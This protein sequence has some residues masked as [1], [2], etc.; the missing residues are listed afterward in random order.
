MYI[1][2]IIF[3]AIKMESVKEVS[4]EFDI[5]KVLFI[6]E[7]N[8][9]LTKSFNK[10]FDITTT[11]SMVSSNALPENVMEALKSI[12]QLIIL[13]D[14]HLSVKYSNLS[15]DNLEVKK[16]TDTVATKT[17]KY[18]KWLGK[19]AVE[20][21]IIEN[22]G[23]KTELHSALLAMND[24]KNAWSRANRFLIK[25]QV[26]GSEIDKLSLR[27]II[28]LG[29]TFNKHMDSAITSKDN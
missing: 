7:T 24:I 10:S 25:A 3:K 15:S 11:K 13:N 22:G 23:V 27:E 8:D 29:K 4:V 2:T 26:D 18:P 12:Y 21:L 19:V 28:A 5:N 14:D 1:C 9:S 6:I 16:P 20:Q 17:K